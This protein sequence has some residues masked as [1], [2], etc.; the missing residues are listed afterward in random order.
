MTK[1]RL[2]SD[3]I[4]YMILFESLTGATVKDCV[5]GTNAMGF[6]IKKGDMGLA[7]GRGGANIEKVRDVIGKSVWVVEFSDDVENFIKNLFQPIKVKRVR[8]NNKENKRT[9]IIEVARRDKRNVVGHEGNRINIA[10]QLA[11]R[12]TNIDDIN[13]QVV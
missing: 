4:K 6:V 5:R 12:H 10:K 3:E 9:A 1:I 11:K 13:I 2:T 8:I 7:I